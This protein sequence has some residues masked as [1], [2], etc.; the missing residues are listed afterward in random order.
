MS[1]Y[2]EGRS[3]AEICDGPICESMARIGELWKSE[4]TGVFIEHRATDI[5]IQALNQLRLTFEPPDGAPVAVGGAPAGD[6]YLLPSLM[7]AT[8]LG[9]ERLRP[10]NLGPDTPPEAFLAACEKHQPV[11]VWLSISSE[12]L[13]EESVRATRRLIQRLDQMSISVVT[14]GRSRHRVGGRLPDRVH[15]AGA[16]GEL[17]AYVR[18]LLS[19]KGEAH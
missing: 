15:V 13:S 16:M 11:L 14:G 1:L 10:I 5:C 8:V 4:E 3:I 7:A 18:A 17:L 6:P 9:A 12:R 2:L 19:V